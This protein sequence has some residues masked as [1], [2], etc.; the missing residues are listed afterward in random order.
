MIDAVF[1][2]H[3]TTIRNRE[4]GLKWTLKTEN[5]FGDV[6]ALLERNFPWDS[7]KS[8]P[9][10]AKAAAVINHVMT[11]AGLSFSGAPGKETLEEAENP[12]CLFGEK[13][14]GEN[15]FI[16]A[17]FIGGRDEIKP[18]KETSDRVEGMRIQY[19]MTTAY[20]PA[21]ITG[22]E[23]GMAFDGL[24]NVTELMIA[25]L[26]YYVRND[27]KLVKCAH[28]GKWF[29]TKAPKQ[30]YCNRPSP[31]VVKTGQVKDGRFLIRSDDALPCKTAVDRIKIDQKNKYKALCEKL[32]WC[33]EYDETGEYDELEEFKKQCREYGR[34]IKKAPT[35][36]NLINYSRF[37]IGYNE[38][39][40]N[41][42]KI[43]GK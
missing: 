13:Q 34:E 6:Y 22:K 26:F 31:C 2:L 16:L 10:E 5:L 20:L 38:E 28:C 23:E 27:L 25:T 21:H 12:I 7:G 8:T 41:R 37:L 24:R 15:R 14:W 43:G 19:R 40:R 42:K 1:S 17:E 30:K 33:G 35:V 32:S 9:T 36:E 18:T 39:L 4:K 29:A 3:T 11:G